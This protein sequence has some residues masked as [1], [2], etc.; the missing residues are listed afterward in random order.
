MLEEGLIL[1]GGAPLTPPPSSTQSQD[2]TYARDH[3]HEHDVRTC[4]TR[5]EG[6]G[7]RWGAMVEKWK[8][9]REEDDCE[10]ECQFEGE[11]TRVLEL[12]CFCLQYS[13]MSL[14]LLPY[15][16]YSLSLS[17]PPS[18][19]FYLSPLAHDLH[20]VH[21]PRAASPKVCVE[22]VEMDGRGRDEGGCYTP[23]NLGGWRDRERGV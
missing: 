2:P 11:R 10:R 15:R 21:R 22:G 7:V 8:N 19:L 14:C 3:V 9:K 17:S 1:L 6:R 4:D 23:C 16:S 12:R 5:G 13:L 18:L 20:G